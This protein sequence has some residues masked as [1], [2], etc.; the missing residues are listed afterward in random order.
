MRPTIKDIF[1]FVS[2]LMLGSCSNELSRKDA[3]ELIKEYYGY[4][5][6]YRAQLQQSGIHTS[7]LASLNRLKNAGLIVVGTKKVLG[8]VVHEFRFTEQG[9]RFYVGKG[10]FSPISGELTHVISHVLELR[11]VTGIQFSPEKTEAVV[12]Y[13]AYISHYTPFGE[14]ALGSGLAQAKERVPLKVTL[15]MFD[16][17]W[18]V[19]DLKA[20]DLNENVLGSFDNYKHIFTAQ[21]HSAKDVTDEVI[22]E[23]V[24]TIQSS[25]ESVTD[26]LSISIV[27][28][29]SAGSYRIEWNTDYQYTEWVGD[30]WIAQRNGNELQ[31]KAGEYNAIPARFVYNPKLD[32]IDF[33]NA[34]I[35][36]Y[37]RFLRVK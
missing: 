15:V 14:Y 29:H 27:D 33:Y 13:D 25:D 7:Q 22:G 2:I 36:G 11:E 26:K 32:V 12:E 24:S 17:G 19:S 3:Q 6:V 16:D 34:N 21:E 5:Q 4:P 35:N 10:S 1:L 9:K 37:D 8:G 31:S 23:W 30:V 20:N 28:G 18:R